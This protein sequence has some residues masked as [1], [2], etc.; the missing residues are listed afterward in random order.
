MKSSASSSR[1]AS[2]RTRSPGGPEGPGGPGAGESDAGLFDLLAE[3]GHEQVSF[4]SDP[5]SGYRGIIAIHDTTLGPGLGGTRFWPYASDREALLDVLR[6]ARSMTYKNA[7][8][9]LTSGGGKAVIIADPANARRE[10]LFR[11]H[12]R[13]IQALHGRYITA[14]DV[15]TSPA[16]MAIIRA[17]TPY[18]TGL[19]GR[20]GDPSPVTAWGV[21]RGMQACAR[22]RYGADSLA[23]RTVAIQGVGHVGYALARLLREGGAKLIVTDL[24]QGKVRRAVEELGAQ[25]V[26][27]DEIYGV[28]ADIFA[29]CALGGVIN[30][31]TL[32]RLRA[33]IVAGGANNQLAEDRHGDRLAER[34][35]LYAPDFAINGGG[36]INLSAELN[37]WSAEYAMERAGGI[38]DTILRVF[39]V[40]E[41]EGISSAR[42]AERLA[43]RRIA[44][45]RNRRGSGAS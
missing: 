36:V 17:E 45:A 4:W 22:S 40:A 18:V 3:H 25:G 20:S 21:Y 35:V 43:E 31:R 7:L 26:E 23:G 19:V 27:A 13:H 39:A 28:A 5:A 44:A 32:P 12:G 9:D 8:A 29:P 30:D 6:L 41:Q 42:A 34:G 14:E 10:P 37:G 15:G 16:D 11:A 38:Y 2:A 1:A 33:A 24:D